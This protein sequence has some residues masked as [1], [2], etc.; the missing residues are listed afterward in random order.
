MIENIISIIFT[1]PYFVKYFLS[2]LFKNFSLFSH[3]AQ[4]R[5]WHCFSAAIAAKSSLRAKRH[6]S[7]NRA[8]FCKQACASFP[9]SES[10]CLNSYLKIKRISRK[11]GRNSFGKRAV[12][13]AFS[14]SICEA[15]FFQKEV[16]IFYIPIGIIVLS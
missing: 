10:A 1:I 5:S 2:K 13:A 8:N 9:L 16:L 7:S 6:M 15:F 12:F 11:S 4:I 14:I 3:T